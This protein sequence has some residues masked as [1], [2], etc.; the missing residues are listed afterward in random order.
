MTSTE[1]AKRMESTIADLFGNT[2]RMSDAEAVTDMVTDL[3]HWLRRRGEGN[4]DPD[5]IASCVEMA[6]SHYEAEIKTE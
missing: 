5:F 3:F 4:T 6:H 1:R 2:N